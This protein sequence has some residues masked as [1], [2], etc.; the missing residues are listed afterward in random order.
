MRGSLV[1]LSDNGHPSEKGCSLLHGVNISSGK[2]QKFFLNPFS[3]DKIFNLA[4]YLV[5]TRKGGIK[6]SSDRRNDK[7]RRLQKRR[8][9]LEGLNLFFR[10]RK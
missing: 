9:I 5:W 10:G 6:I 7:M 2:L 8:G 4:N 1:T 3:K